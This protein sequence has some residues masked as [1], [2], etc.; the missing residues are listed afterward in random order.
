ML[1]IG[2]S[3]K[4]EQKMKETER[5]LETIVN[6][7]KP[8]RGLDMKKTI[9]KILQKVPI[10]AIVLLIS[11]LMMGCTIRSR[12][13]IPIKAGNVKAL[14]YATVKDVD[15]LLDIDRCFSLLQKGCCNEER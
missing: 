3:V 15:V 4:G 9:K 2:M 8:K 11:F 14:P 1:F 7:F 13:H 12:K 10:I 5:I 6:V